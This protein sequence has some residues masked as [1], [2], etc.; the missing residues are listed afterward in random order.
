ME[1]H[2]RKRWIGKIAGL[3][4]ATLGGALCSVVILLQRQHLPMPMAGLLLLAIVVAVAFAQLP[5]WRRL[6][7]MQRDSHL[8]SWYWGG[9]FGGGIAIVSIVLATGTKSQMATGALLVWLAQ[10][11]GYGIWQLRWRIVHRAH[12]S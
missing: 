2:A 4:T 10:A 5:W 1:R 6:D 12:A 3:G 7:H 8:S 9:A 11:L